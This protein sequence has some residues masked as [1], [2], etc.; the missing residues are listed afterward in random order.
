MDPAGWGDRAVLPQRRPHLVIQ[1]EHDGQRYCGG[2]GVDQDLTI[3]EI[4]LN[5]HKTSSFLDTVV[6]DAAVAV[7]IALQHGAKIETIKADQI[8]QL[9][10]TARK[11]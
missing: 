10:N 9:T 4:W 6:C 5:S 11:K 7:S 8:P 3:R 2:Y 1:F